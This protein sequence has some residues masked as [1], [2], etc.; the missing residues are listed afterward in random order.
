MKKNGRWLSVEYLGSRFQGQEKETCPGF[1]YAQQPK[2]RVREKEHQ[3]SQHSA[4]DCSHMFKPIG[5][6]DEI[7]LA[8]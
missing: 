8:L 2:I 4:L 5:E 1:L 6:V 3:G 7:P